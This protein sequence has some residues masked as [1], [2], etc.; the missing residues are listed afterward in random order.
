MLNE[1]LFGPIKQW[2]Y[3]VKDLD[4][5]M[6]FW[7]E[8]LGVGPWWGYRN[9][10]MEADLHGQ[11][12]QITMDVGL[13]FQNGVQI[14]LIHQTNDAVSPYRDFYLSDKEQLMHQ[15]AYFTPDIDGAIATAVKQGMTQQGYCKTPLGQRYVYME[16]AL[17]GDVV[18][19]LMEVDEGFVA[20]Y[21]RCAKEAENWDGSDPYRLITF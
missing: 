20:E 12:G 5:S 3:L 2:G 13:A 14:E 1:S 11:K 16:N 6:K 8:V 7:T 17:L 9:I 4:R 18:A 15:I 19:E 10:S 21:E